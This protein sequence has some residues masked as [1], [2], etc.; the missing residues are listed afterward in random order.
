MAELFQDLLDARGDLGINGIVKG[1]KE[2]VTQG[3]I[4]SLDDT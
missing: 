3:L 4:L 2:S 1:V